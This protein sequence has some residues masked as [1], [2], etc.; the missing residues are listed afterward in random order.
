MARS[1]GI[2]GS[3]IGSGPMGETERG[4]A[5]ARVAVS[6][7]CEAGH[8]TR[9]SFAATAVVPLVWECPGCGLP[10]GRDRD[11]PPVHTPAAPYKTHLAY[12]RERRSEA[13]AEILLAEALA[14]L[15][16]TG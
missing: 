2:R 5:A 12:V 1:S 15:R 11:N 8:V 4:E 7:W 9:P 6:F 10:A 13:E 14:R 16:A 3:R